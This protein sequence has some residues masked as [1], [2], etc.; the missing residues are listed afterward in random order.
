MYVYK[1]MQGYNLM[2]AIAR[3]NR[4]FRDKEGGLVVDYVGI[5]SA[6]KQAM[7][8]Y[9]VRDKKNYGDTDVAK[10]A[11]PKFLEKLSI[12][13]DLFHHYEDVY[14]RQGLFFNTL[15]NQLGKIFRFVRRNFENFL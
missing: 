13:Q 3:V 5:A 6:L 14:K 11:Y 9:T 7:N 4:V 12:C 10:V 8:D 1:P 2:Q 15:T